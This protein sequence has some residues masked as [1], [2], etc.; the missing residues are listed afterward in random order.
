MYTADTYI[1]MQQ[2]VFQK[3]RKALLTD[4]KHITFFDAMQE[5]VFFPGDLFVSNNIF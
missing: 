1:F 3:H 2:F 5:D 4:D